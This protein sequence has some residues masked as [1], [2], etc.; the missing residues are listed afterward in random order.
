MNFQT[1]KQ[2]KLIQTKE[3]EFLEFSGHRAK[4]GPGPRPTAAFAGQPTRRTACPVG[5]GGPLCVAHDPMR[6][7]RVQHLHGDW[8]VRGSAL[9]SLGIRQSAHSALPWRGP[10]RAPNSQTAARCSSMA[11]WLPH[12]PARQEDASDRA[13]EQDDDMVA[14]HTP[15]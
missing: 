13:P 8:S 14:C 15:F 6:P 5:T 11:S 4:T 3:K 7:A 10:Q 9:G 2:S 1:L 12:A